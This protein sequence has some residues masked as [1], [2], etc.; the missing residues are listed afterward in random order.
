[1][2]SYFVALITVKDPDQ[3]G[4]YLEG[5]M[6]IFERYAG[7][8]LAA[9]DA[10]EALE[11]EWPAARTVIIRFPSEEELLR[12]YRSPEYQRLI[13]LRRSAADGAIALVH[14]LG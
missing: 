7:E 2:S 9:D 10:P 5:F 1:M 3:Y 14:G 8:V 12:W 13:E 4:R 11:G 6:P